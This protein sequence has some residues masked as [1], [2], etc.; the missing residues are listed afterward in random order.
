[1]KKAG[2]Y[3]QVRS[4]LVLGE[5]ISQAASFVAGG[6]ADAGVVALSLALSVNMKDKGKFAE[7]PADSYPPIEQGCVIVKGSNK[8]S[9]A[10]AFLEFVK[11]PKAQELLKKYGFGVAAPKAP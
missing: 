2:V 5:N 11:S 3:E 1:M 8:K 6:A 10:K 7:I 4:K 9:A